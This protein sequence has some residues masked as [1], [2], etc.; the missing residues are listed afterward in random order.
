MPIP[1]NNFS[2]NCIEFVNINSSG[3][4]FRQVTSPISTSGSLV[5]ESFTNGSIPGNAIIDF[6]EGGDIQVNENLNMNGYAVYEMENIQEDLY[7]DYLVG[8]GINLDWFT[9]FLNNEVI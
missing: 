6:E 3:F 1:L 9:S 7:D 4:R 2:Q 8:Q 5:L